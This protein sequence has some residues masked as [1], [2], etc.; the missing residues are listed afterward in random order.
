M[1]AYIKIITDKSFQQ[2]GLLVFGI[3]FQLAF[4][5][6]SVHFFEQKK[7][8]YRGSVYF[9]LKKKN[10]QDLLDYDSEFD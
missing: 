4:C 6:S 5:N 2:T 3:P 10:Y 7:L 1:V 8:L 9:N